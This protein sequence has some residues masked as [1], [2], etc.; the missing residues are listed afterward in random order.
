MSV[1]FLFLNP[2]INLSKLLSRINASDIPSARKVLSRRFAFNC[3]DRSLNPVFHWC[4]SVHEFHAYPLWSSLP[5][6]HVGCSPTGCF[7]PW[8]ACL[9]SY[10]W[11]WFRQVCWR[12]SSAFVGGLR[13]FSMTL[14]TPSLSFFQ[15]SSGSLRHSA[16]EASFLRRAVG[17]PLA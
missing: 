2:V 5:T 4:E 1:I 11:Y 16:S 7:C 12:D 10:C 3:S 8:L 6:P 17:Q 15:W 13:F 9:R 14:C